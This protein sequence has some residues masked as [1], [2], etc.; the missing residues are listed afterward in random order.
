[1][2]DLKRLYQE[3]I[4]DHNKHPRNYEHL[5]EPSHHAHGDNPLCGDTYDIEIRV[6]DGE[7]VEVGFAGE[8]CA[9]SK[10]AAS[11]M[12]KHI[13]GTSVGEVEDLIEAFRH[14]LTDK[15]SDDEMEYLGHLKAFKGVS[16][17]PERIKCAVLPWHT[18][19]AAL[20]GEDE[21]STEGEED[22]W[23]END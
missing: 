11:M 22:L 15:A 19:G 5:D 17:H 6:E 7:V 14:M 12:T 2:K 9:I 21:V 16:G 20:E 13:K 18:L 10:A 1:M 3:V 8:G 23:G 4:L